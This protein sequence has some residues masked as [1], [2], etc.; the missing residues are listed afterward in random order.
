MSMVEDFIE[1]RYNVDARLIVRGK[2]EDKEDGLAAGRDYAATEKK[3]GWE[4]D[5]VTARP[6]PKG[7]WWIEVRYRPSCPV[8]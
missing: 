7:W 1:Q 2:W 3:E 5:Q 6:H 4:F 8:E